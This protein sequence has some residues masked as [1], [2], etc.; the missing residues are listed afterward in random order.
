MKQQ[1]NQSFTLLIVPRS[2]KKNPKRALLNLRITINGSRSEFSIHRSIDSSKWDYTRSKAKGTSIEARKV[3]S[4]I[5]EVKNNLLDIYDDLR[6][7]NTVID[8]ITIKRKYLKLDQ[9]QNTLI[10]LFSYHEKHHFPKIKEGTKKHFRTLYRYSKEFLKVDLKVNDIFLTTLSYSYLVKFENFL[11]SKRCPSKTLMKR[12]SAVKHIQ[13]LKTIINLGIKLE[14]M[15]KDPFVSYTC[16][17]DK[18]DRGYLTQQELD[19][20][21]QKQ[22]TIPRLQFIR[23]IF[24]FSCYCGLPYMDAISI[25]M[26]QISLGIDGERWIVMERGKNDHLFK[27]PLL[28]VAGRLVDQYS[29]DPRS[30]NRG[31]IFPKISNQKLNSYLKEIADI[32]SIRKNLTFHLA[33]HTFATTVTLSNGVPIETVSKLLGHTQISTTQIYARV[34]D[35]KISS[36]MKNLKS[37]LALKQNDNS[38]DKEADIRKIS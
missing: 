32:C 25:T 14:W 8:A 19:S 4:Y 30:I 15:D 11:L 3:N 10:A 2:S 24:V 31:T 35:T 7:S 36:D 17:Y 18:V 33:R 20:I 37:V 34:L 23:D 16:T 12:N 22:I 28:P 1:F 5:L 29:K 38:I 26:D 27:V 13:R 6:K 21:E 9:P